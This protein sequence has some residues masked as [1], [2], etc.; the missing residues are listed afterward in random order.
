MN[1][2]QLFIT[3]SILALGTA[4]ASAQSAID[5][6]SLSRNDFKGTARFMSMGGAFG[7][8]GGD[9]SVL[10]QN[11]GGI[12]IYRS[13]DVALT[14]DLDMQKTSSNTGGFKMNDTQTKFHVNNFGYIGAINTGSEAIPFVNFGAS[15]T[16][17]NSFDRRF[18]GQNNNISGSFSNYI[19]G[20]TSAS[21]SYEGWSQS[22]LTD[23][24]NAYNPYQDSWAPWMSILAYNAYMINPRPG[25]PDNANQYQG[26]WQNGSTG[27]SFMSYEEKGYVDEYNIDFGGN[28]MNLLYWG[29]GFGITDINYTANSF[30]DEE[31]DNASIPNATA[32]GVT[33]GNAYYGLDSWKHITG[34]GF[35]FKLGVIVKPINELRLGLAIHTPTYYNLTQQS[36]AKVDYSYAPYAAGMAGYESSTET[37]RGWNYELAWKLRT[38]WRLIAS[39]AGVI[40]NRAILSADYEY[41]PYQDMSIR[42]SKDHAFTYAGESSD[43][44]KGD[45]NSYYQS[46]SILRI[47]GEYRL[48]PSWSVRA[49]VNYETSPSTD[50]ASSINADI[51]TEGPEDCGTMPAFT[52]DKSTTY[53]TCGLGYRYQSFYIDAAYIHKSMKADYRPY[54]P[55]DYTSTWLSEITTNNSQLVLTLGLRF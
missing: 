11:P 37:N 7:A 30:Y 28:V 50:Y 55:N 34:S 35:N 47:G 26:L 5:A 29:L 48:T 6:F 31:I 41:R 44:L 13:N 38:P 45:I 12:G 22:A 8:L 54:T 21:G 18:R 33:D 2:R 27:N 16:R 9:I 52:M 46:S 49:G 40:G 3:A 36:W 15:Y 20:A 1:T 19:A 4:A 32:T 51:Y 39:V 42:N 43:Y 17:L 10:T 24:D 23:Y 53:L 14:F 25:T